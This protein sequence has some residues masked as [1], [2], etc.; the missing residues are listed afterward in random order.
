MAEE[1]RSGGGVGP[2]F[3][4]NI[5]IQVTYLSSAF[6]SPM[7]RKEI[8]GVRLQLAGSAGIAS[9]LAALVL[10]R[11]PSIS[12]ILVRIPQTHRRA[13]RRRWEPVALQPA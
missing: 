7:K 8:S 13:S 5:T 11:S 6:S 1:G 10:S 9:Q 3:M 12:R 4:R 2:K